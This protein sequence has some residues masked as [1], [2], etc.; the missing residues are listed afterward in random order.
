MRKSKKEK[1]IIYSTKTVKKGE[2]AMPSV[3]KLL[4][5]KNSH[6]LTV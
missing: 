5:K 3:K 6:N 4:K 2:S 1:K